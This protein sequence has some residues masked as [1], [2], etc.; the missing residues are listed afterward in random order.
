[1]KK[2]IFLVEDDPLD[3]ISVERSLGKLN[4]AHELWTA[5]N[6]VEALNVLKKAKSNNQLPNVILLDIN[7]P[8]RNGV[9]F[10]KEVRKEPAYADIKIYV[11][12]TSSEDYDN[13][14]PLGVEGYIIKP[15]N[16]TDNLKRTSSM[17]NFMQFHLHKILDN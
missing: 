11:M 10:L 12:T 6:G 3:V 17:D 7:M 9:E 5:Y 2:V 15:L 14:L 13:V 16:F 8:K 4:I 1:M